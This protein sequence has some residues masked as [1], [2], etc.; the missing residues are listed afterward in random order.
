MQR[1]R[2]DVMWALLIGAA[3]ASG[4]VAAMTLAPQTSASGSSSVV[5]DE[6]S[7]L[8][9]A[10][11]RRELNEG[12][13]E[14]LLEQL[15]LLDRLEDAKLLVQQWLNQQP[16]S[17]ALGLLM[18]DLHRRS[19]ALEAARREL[20]QLLRLHPSNQE[21]LQLAVLVDLQDGR[22]QNALQLLQSQFAQRPEGQR[23]ELGLLLADLQRQL[24]QTKAAASSY[25]KLAKESAEDVSA[26]IALA[27]LHQ[28]Q[29][30]AAE[31]ERW[32]DQ[33]RL[34]RGNDDRPDP[35]IDELAYRWGLRAARVRAEQQRPEVS[36]PAP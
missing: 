28:E 11:Q 30:D 27:M 24:G 36:A 7:Q 15:L 18:A 14:R 20:E 22:G 25:Q 33:A 23:L 6:V 34:R 19:G 4:W 21:L 3:V 29:G 1:A 13:R 17:L 35:M 9:N 26:V 10:K 12:E 32:L 2:R 16:H 8:L 31:V 5:D